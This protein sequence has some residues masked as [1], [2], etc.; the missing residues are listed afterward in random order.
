[1]HVYR[2]SE[3]D[4]T[5]IPRAHPWTTA[6]NNARSR[7]VDFRA[8]PEKIATA[9]E[10]FLPFADERAIQKFYDLLRWINGPD[11]LLESNDCAFLFKP[12]DDPNRPFQLE[13]S[14]RVM[15]F[16]TDISL[17]CSPNFGDMLMGIFFSRL[18]VCLP[19][20]SPAVVGVS[21]ASSFFKEA[22]KVGEQVVLYF[23]AW[24]DTKESTFSTLDTLFGAMLDAAKGVSSEIRRAISNVTADGP[25]TNNCTR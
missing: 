24:G 15:L 2:A 19:Q 20:Q 16:V 3:L 14:G 25:K 6:E 9:L 10:D 12:N 21:R 5:G 17:T 18:Q 11:S 1:M 8:E 4:I 23:W 13:A 22:R 7:Y